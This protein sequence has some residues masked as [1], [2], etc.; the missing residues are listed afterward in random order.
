MRGSAEALLR[1]SSLLSFHHHRNYEQ[2]KQL[3][4]ETITHISK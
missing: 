1:I 3:N 2:Q 4:N